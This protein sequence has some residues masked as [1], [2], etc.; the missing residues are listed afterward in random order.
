MSIERRS[1][2][3]P[4]RAPWGLPE[5]LGVE[6]ARVRYPQPRLHYVGPQPVEVREAVELLVRTADE[7][8]ILRTLSPAL[9][10]GETA[11]PEYNRVGKNLYRFFAFDLRRLKEGAPISIGWPQSPQRKV[12]TKF[13]YHLRGEAR[14]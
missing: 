13:R 6:A 8:P 12:R 1:P 14:V 4:G 3:V 9:F 2:N 5:V 10:V 11:V 7:F